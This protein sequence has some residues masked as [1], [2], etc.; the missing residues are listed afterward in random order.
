METLPGGVVE[1]E[2][3]IIEALKREF[4]EETNLDIVECGQL[5]YVLQNRL[6]ALNEEGLVLAFHVQS[7]CGELAVVDDEFV[8]RAKF[9]PIEELRFTLASPVGLIPLERFLETPSKGATFYYFDDCDG[10]SKLRFT[11]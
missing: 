8:R 9:V 11:Q 2:E 4:R 7:V 10:E 6:A 3:S 5:G 1:P